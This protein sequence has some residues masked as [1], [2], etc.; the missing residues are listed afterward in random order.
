MSIRELGNYLIIAQ[1]NLINKNYIA[2]EDSH[3]KE[4]IYS[5]NSIKNSYFPIPD[6]KNLSSLF[7]MINNLSFIGN[8]NIITSLVNLA[9]TRE[10]LLFLNIIYNNTYK[11]L[12]EKWVRLI[13]LIKLVL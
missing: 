2:L 13:P 10:Y 1:G 3:S 11:P 12:F 5:F 7:N 9:I 6:I 8:K 4:I